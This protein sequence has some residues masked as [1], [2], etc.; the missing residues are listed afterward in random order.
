MRTTVR[1]LGVPWPL[2][3]TP[4][5]LLKASA[6]WRICWARKSSPVTTLTAEPT[7]STGTPSTETALSARPSLPLS[8]DGAAVSPAP[9]GPGP[10]A[11]FF[12]GFAGEATSVAPSTT[13]GGS[14]VA[15]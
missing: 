8:P 6:A 7:S 2:T 9:A 11:G 3:E 10:W 12:F 14:S 15:S 4:G 5:R 13:M 1:L